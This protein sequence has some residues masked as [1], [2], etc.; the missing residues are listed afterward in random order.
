MAR[1]IKKIIIK[2]LAFSEKLG[3]FLIPHKVRNNFRR[4]L[5]SIGFDDIPYRW[6]AYIAYLL[7]AMDVVI[8]Y[9]VIKNVFTGWPIVTKM[10]V[11]IFSFAI[12]GAL[13]GL[14]AYF[15]FKIYYTNML[16]GRVKEIEA[17][18]PD[19]LTELNLHLR[20]GMVLTKALEHSVNPEYGFLNEVIKEINLQ[21][22][23]GSE[24]MDAF[25]KTIDKYPSPHLSEA[26]NLIGK[27][28]GEGGKTIFLVDRLIENMN[29][30]IYLKNETAANVGTYTFFIT[31][32]ALVI[33]P[34]LFVASYHVLLL[35]RDMLNKVVASGLSLQGGLTLSEITVDIYDFRLFT[36]I[37]TA[38]TAFCAAY[39]MAII[40]EGTV[41]KS[42]K[43]ISGFV[44]ISIFSYF[45]FYLL[46]GKIFQYFAR[47]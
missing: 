7:L 35:I 31:L 46:L 24:V 20:S 15:G 12:I 30:Y 27:S 18:M 19:F 29:T 38:I 14:A 25:K 47:V 21:I 6:F 32:I 16:Y 17:A 44:I 23:M 39:I 28:S 1:R 43:Y 3:D 34:A 9:F 10:L 13:L 11:G 4:S 5:S 37:A 26:L 42:F 40:K 22:K 45:V 41:K 2:P 8:N 33:S 36:I